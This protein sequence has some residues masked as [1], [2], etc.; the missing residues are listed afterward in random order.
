VPT[1]VG[2]AP[3]NPR[4]KVRDPFEDFERVG[5]KD[6]RPR[7]PPVGTSGR[8]ALSPKIKADAYSRASSIGETLEEQFGLG[9][10][11]LRQ[12]VFG[13][14]RRRDLYI[15]AA[16][17]TSNDGPNKQVLQDLADKCLDTAESSAGATIGT[18]IHAMREQ[19]DAGVDLSHVP[20]DVRDALDKWVEL[21]TG[22]EVLASEAKTVCD[23]H[24][25]A[26]T[27][28]VLLRL[29]GPMVTPDGTVLP[30]G[31]IVIGDLKTS[32]TSDYFGCKFAVQL[33][34]YAHAIPFDVD[35]YMRITWGQ[36]VRGLD[37]AGDE[38]FKPHSKWAL[39]IHIPTGAPKE[40]G[41]YWVDVESGEELTELAFTVRAQRRRK[42]L[43][44]KAN[45][46]LVAETMTPARL[47]AEILGCQTKAQIDALW[48]AHRP[49]SGTGLWDQPETYRNGPHTRAG[50]KRLD[51]IAQIEK[52]LAKVG[53]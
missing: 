27:F 39:V 48:E 6:Q 40:G 33:A 1:K 38:D 28:D 32:T 26:G 8:E 47:M 31:T 36:L 49:G 2:S 44:V 19:H 29:L 9:Q 43:V 51:E 50:R 7:I 35:T 37:Y 53:A 17:V 25:V 30:A 24:R 10:W 20:E 4:G 21:T 23:K 34:E 15:A 22:F 16:A 11:R 12:V 42:D 45:P 14:G 52:T 18:A 41:L 13:M 5:G 46:P 3:Q